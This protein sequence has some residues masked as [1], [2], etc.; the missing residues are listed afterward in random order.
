MNKKNLIALACCFVFATLVVLTL[1][2]ASYKKVHSPNSFLREYRKAFA[3]KAST[4]DIT[5]SSYYIAG[6]TNEH[7]YLGNVTA[8]F[9][10][11]IVNHAL[12]DSQ[13]VHLKLKNEANSWVYKKTMITVDS[14]YFYMADGIMPAV[15]RGRLGEWQAE[16]IISDAAYFTRLIPLSHSSFAIRT[17]GYPS[18]EN[19]L[20]KL[21]A[22]TP[23]VK[24]EPTL[25]EKQ[26]DGRFC[27]DGELF[28]N[29]DLKKL[30]YTYYY[31]NGYVVYDTNLNLTYRG[32]TIDT[33]KR[34]QIKVGYVDSDNS[35]KLTYKKFI[36]T[37]STTSG[38]Y[39][40]I[41]S[42]LL[43]KNDSEHLFDKMSAIDVYDLRSKAYAFSF[44]L[45][46]YPAEAKPNN[47]AVY[48]NEALFSVSGNY[49]IRYNLKSKYL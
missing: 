41:R 2:G 9:R 7:I 30:V 13:R 16:R 5:Y 48:K 24:L 19:V 17:T 8:P 44:T 15:F 31:R 43:A 39:L 26:I 11:L 34:A 21:Q 23:R 49:L 27:T 6:V 28:Y 1:Y 22:D 35:R 40:Y 4:M 3:A 33:F 45:T 42:G 46:N 25:L 12:T 36:N 14:P 47:F 38:N 18:L 29:R 32:H 20:G 10:L 37:R